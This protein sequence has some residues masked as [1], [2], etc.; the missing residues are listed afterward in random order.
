M[1]GSLQKIKIAWFLQDF[2][3]PYQEYIKNLY[4]NLRKSYQI[5]I[6]IIT[7]NLLDKQI[8]GDY[9]V[10]QIKKLSVFDNI[11]RWLTFKEYSKV[12]DILGSFEIIHIQHSFLYPIISKL[13]ASPDAPKFVITFRGSESYIKPWINPK[14]IN[15][16][17]EINGRFSAIQVMSDNQKKYIEKWGYDSSNAYTIPISTST[18]NDLFVNNKIQGAIRICSIFRMTW[19]KNIEANLRLIAEMVKRGRNVVYNVYGDGSD[20]GQLYYLVDRFGLSNVVRLHG[21]VAPEAFSNEIITNHL[22]F[23][24]SSSEALPASVIEA[25]SF[26]IPCVVSDVGGFPEIIYNNVNGYLMDFDNY[27]IDGAADFV[28]SI[29]DDDDL[30]QRLKV[31]AFQTFQEKFSPSVE[32]KKIYQMYLSVFES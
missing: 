5:S 24:L 27:N 22:L 1:E 2:P 21:R 29:I 26:G 6:T 11:I 25:L 20:F 12:E 15:F 13:A 31:G 30:Y 7:Y 14:W 9:E 8:T 10:R 16:H 17:R 32:A 28:E 18:R 19:E 4:L 23:Q 3:N